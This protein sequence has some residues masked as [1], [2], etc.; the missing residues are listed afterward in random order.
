MFAAA[1]LKAGTMALLPGGG[2]EGAESADAAGLKAGRGRRDP[3][4]NLELWACFDA[5]NSSCGGNLRS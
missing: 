4:P 1:G 3:L 2:V 5:G